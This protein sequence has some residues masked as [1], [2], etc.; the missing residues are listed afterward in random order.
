MFS[1]YN[2]VHLQGTVLSRSVATKIS[3][4]RIVYAAIIVTKIRYSW[5][6]FWGSA[7]H[8]LGVEKFQTDIG[9]ASA[10]PPSTIKQMPTTLTIIV[11][12]SFVLLWVSVCPVSASDY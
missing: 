5:R 3:P 12:I 2:T 4:V 11:G 1:N 6:A 10:Y 8:W 9:R 7:S